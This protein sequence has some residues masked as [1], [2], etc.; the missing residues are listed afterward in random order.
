MPKADQ[1]GCGTTEPGLFADDDIDAHGVLHQ[2]KHGRHGHQTGPD[3]STA[4]RAATARTIA[5]GGRG[6]AGGIGSQPWRRNDSHSC[7]SNKIPKSRKGEA[8]Q[9]AGQVVE[10]AEPD[11]G[12]INE[13]DGAATM[14]SAVPAGLVNSPEK[15]N[16]PSHKWLGYWLTIVGHRPMLQDFVPVRFSH[17]TPRPEEAFDFLI[18]S[19]ANMPA[20]T[21]FSDLRPHC[22]HGKTVNG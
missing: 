15:E 8:G 11:L 12:P 10:R 7:R 20:L 17:A 4:R 3:A 9:E 19:F 14:F 5:V 1:W 16:L 2:E 6:R 13:Q 18:P 22:R 21:G